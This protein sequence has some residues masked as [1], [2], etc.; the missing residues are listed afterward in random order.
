[1][2]GAIALLYSIPCENLSDQALVEPSAT[3]LVIRE[4]LLRGAELSEGLSGKTATGGMLN[5]YNSLILL[6]ES[7]TVEEVEQNIKVNK[8]FP[9]PTNNQV[10][11]EYQTSD[12]GVYAVQIFNSLGQVVLR[13]ELKPA[14]FG[15]RKEA[16]NLQNLAP[17]V[18]HIM[19]DT[20]QERITRKVM[21][22]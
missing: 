8:I 3:A 4:A 12:F 2:T 6:Q 10:F 20:E 13:D 21:V 15:P 11:I 19:I 5:V 22:Y 14:P 7:C 1:M 18:Y 16:F 9:N 17:G